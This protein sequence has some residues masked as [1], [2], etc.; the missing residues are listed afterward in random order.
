[1]GAIWCQLGSNLAPKTLPKWR[2]VGT[3]VSYRGS[4]ESKGYADMHGGR[5]DKVKHAKGG[6]QRMHFD[7]LL[8][9]FGRAEGWPNWWTVARN[10]EHWKS[11]E[12][13]FV[14]FTC[15]SHAWMF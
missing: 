11:F 6:Q 13:K 7:K 2:Q 1:M 3:L 14:T 15:A 5:P 8:S 10:R 12:K 9:E 4:E